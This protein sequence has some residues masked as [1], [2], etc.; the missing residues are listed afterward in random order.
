MD[1]L[2]LFEL[3]YGGVVIDVAVVACPRNAEVCSECVLA[4]VRF[5]AVP[6]PTL[7]TTR[8]P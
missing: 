6:S 4:E 1:P 7:L 3:E 5:D 2:H 8:R